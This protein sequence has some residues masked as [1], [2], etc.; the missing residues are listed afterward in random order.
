MSKAPSRGI[1]ES[2]RRELVDMLARQKQVVAVMH[3]HRL[4]VL[5]LALPLPLT[6]TSSHELEQV[7]RS[8]LGGTATLH[9]HGH[10]LGQA[11]QL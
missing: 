10:A 1:K 2:D 4:A 8:T 7:H 3:R 9:T 11:R 5:R 6:H